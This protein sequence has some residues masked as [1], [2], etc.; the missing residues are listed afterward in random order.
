MSVFERFVMGLIFAA[1]PPIALFNVGWRLCAMLCRDKNSVLVALIGLILGLIID[2]IFFRKILFNAYNANTTIALFIYAFYLLCF[3]LYFKTL[4]IVC[5]VPGIIA[6]FYEGRKL[7]LYKANS[8]ESGYRINRVAT[9]T[10]SGMAI[11]CITSAFFIFLKFEEIITSL[12]HFFNVPNL[13]IEGWMVLI[14][15]IIA[16]VLLI[17]FQYWSARRIALFAMRKDF[18][19]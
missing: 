8:F 10:M 1:A 4:P 15:I 3:L 2:I 19:K 17:V 6:G 7:F 18:T 12:K 13:R 16:S 11:A 5:I 9:L 14:A